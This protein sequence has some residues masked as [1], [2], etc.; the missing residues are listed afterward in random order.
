[1]GWVG[2]ETTRA[3]ER[4]TRSATAEEQ[5][6][7]EALSALRGTPY[8]ETEWE[9]VRRNLLAFAGILERWRRRQPERQQ[10]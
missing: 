3:R 5:K 2:G 9:V 10:R 4:A 1:M 7:H 8:S 6:A